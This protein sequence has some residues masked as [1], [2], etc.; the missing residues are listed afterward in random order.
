MKT[1]FY[2]YQNWQAGTKKR[3]SLHYAEC[4]KCNKGTG[5]PKKKITGMRGVWIG[6]FDNQKLAEEYVETIIGGKV[7]YCSFC[8]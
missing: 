1:K 8:F 4:I 3:L 7:K 6:S 2:L 5:V